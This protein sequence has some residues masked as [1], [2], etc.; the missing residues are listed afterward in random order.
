VLG[1]DSMIHT[2]CPDMMLQ[3]ERASIV[4]DELSTLIQWRIHGRGRGG[5]VPP[6][7]GEGDAH[8]FVPPPDFLDSVLIF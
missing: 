5:R 4:F 7:F 6:E 8:V 1:G 2:G 3:F